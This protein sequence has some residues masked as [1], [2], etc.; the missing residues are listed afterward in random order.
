MGVGS[1]PERCIC[2]AK[3]SPCVECPGRTHPCVTVVF[4]VIYVTLGSIPNGAD[5]MVE[6]F[7]QASSSYAVHLARIFCR[8]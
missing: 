8:T 2:E 6:W 5:P 4:G 1:N 3:C 7:P